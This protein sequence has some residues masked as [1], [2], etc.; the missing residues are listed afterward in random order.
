[1]DGPVSR[2]NVLNQTKSPGS[3]PNGGLTPPD[4]HAHARAFGAG[5]H[6]LVSEVPLVSRVRG[7]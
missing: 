7:T 5:V 2:Y 4:V 1:M 3:V 6:D